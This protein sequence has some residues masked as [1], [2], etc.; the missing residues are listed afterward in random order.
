MPKKAS[1]QPKPTDPLADGPLPTVQKPDPPASLR[2]RY[3]SPH[4]ARIVARAFLKNGG[5]MEA[6]LKQLRPG[7]SAATYAHYGN[8]LLKQPVVQDAINKEL[9]SLGLDDESFRGFL[10][11]IWRRFYV[12]GSRERDRA[13][14][15]LARGFGLGDK[16]DDARKPT[17]LP[18]KGVEDGLKSM[19]AGA[20]DQRDAEAAFNPTGFG[21]MINVGHG[22]AAENVA[23]ALESDPGDPSENSNGD[24]SASE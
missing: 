14:Q 11:E 21:K 13:T 22:D 15:V 6:A 1:L 10:R 7:H 23:A 9:E 18:I 24:D 2:L 5:D 3:N 19:M 16:A 12:G 20:D 17:A 8:E 4:T